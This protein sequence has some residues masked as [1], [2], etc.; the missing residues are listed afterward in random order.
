MK[1]CTTL[2]NVETLGKCLSL[3]FTS[4]GTNSV[5]ATP[6]NFFDAAEIIL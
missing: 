4:N 6:Y 3:G 2:R 5:D 1:P